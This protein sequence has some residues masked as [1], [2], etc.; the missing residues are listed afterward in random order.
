MTD[1]FFKDR[2]DAGIQIA[3]E[4]AKIIPA[5]QPI[6]IL[7]IPRGGM[8]TADEV[9]AF[10]SAPLDILIARKI[11]APNQPELG[12][13]SVTIYDENYFINEALAHMVGVTPD[14]LDQEISYQ[15]QQMEKSMRAYR[16]VR[17]QADIFEKTVVVIDDGMTT[18]YTFRAAL[19]GI[20]L[21]SPE[22][23]IAATPVATEKSIEMIRP[24]TDDIVCLVTSEYFLSISTWYDHYRNVDDHEVISILSRNWAEH[25]S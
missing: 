18:G 10:F 13:G 12:I 17:P 7:G 9:A 1:L 2:R 8:I 14:Y 6:V 5:N 16:K 23:L 21:R 3:A 22:R 25:H 4:L 19:Q 20:Q 15:R 24:F 11:R